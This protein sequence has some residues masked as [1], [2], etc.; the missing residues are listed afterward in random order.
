MRAFVIAME[1]EADA[2]RRHIDPVEDLLIVCGVGKVNAA[3]AT[4]LAID[5]GATEIYN[6][7]FAGG[8]GTEMQVGDVYEVESAVQYDFDLAELN[9]T[10]VGVLNERKDA[11]IPLKTRGVFPA[12]ILATG[13]R[14]TSSTA[15][16]SL[17]KELGCTLRDMEG[18]AIAQICEKAG[19]PCY[20]L[21]CITDVANIEGMV[22]QFELNRETVWWK[23]EAAVGRWL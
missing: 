5:R 9:H 8:F 15:D 21:K 23:L 17:L 6:V 7:G 19:V 11:Y 4:Q 13:D 16:D 2:V 22:K 20:S 3:A 14:F 1:D 12:L 18:G 10:A